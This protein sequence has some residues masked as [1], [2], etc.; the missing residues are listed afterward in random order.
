MAGSGRSAGAPSAPSAGGERYEL[1]VTFAQ[2][3]R[4]WVHGFMLPALGLAEDRV[5]T[6]ERFRP[7]APVVDE[8]ERAVTT[9]RYTVVVVSNA[10]LADAWSTFGE[11]LTSYA[12]VGGADRLIPAVLEPC[13]LPLRVEFRVR[14]D[15]T[16]ESRWE[17]QLARLRDLL[18]QS[19]PRLEELP[20]PYPGMQVFTQDQA[21]W[22]YGR[23]DESEQLLRRLRQ[24][25]L[26][27]VIGPSGAGKSSLV[28]AGVLP[29]LGAGGRDGG[30]WAIRSLRPGAHPTQ[31]LAAA[32]EVGGGEPAGGQRPGEVSQAVAGLLGR[33]GA[34]RLLLVVD[35]LEE[36]FAQAGRGEQTVFFDRLRALRDDERCV[37]LVTVRADFY[38]ELM[39]CPLWPL[40]PGERFEVV[41][42]AGEALGRAIQQPAADVG[43]HLQSALVQRL[44]DDAAGEPGVLP[45][46]QETLVLLWHQRQRRLLTEAAYDRLGGE[47][48]SALTAAIAEKADATVSALSP[49]QR[50]IA[51]RILLRLVQLGE[52]RQDTRR[53]EPIEAL[54]SS[55][56]SP[57]EFEAT[58]Q[59][60]TTNRL[61]TLSGQESDQ[62]RVD[63]AHEA[64][65]TG[66]PQ[67]HDWIRDNRDNLRMQRAIFEDAQH[68]DE[69]DRDPEALY[70]GARLEAAGTWADTHHDELNDL[71]RDFIQAS[72]EDAAARKR[73][74]R[75]TTLLLR[76]LTAFLLIAV[77]SVSFL[78]LQARR[79]SVRYERLASR[80]SARA[81]GVYDTPFEL[82]GLATFMADGST[83][84][85]AQPSDDPQLGSATVRLTDV[86]TGSSRA[87][88]IGAADDRATSIVFNPEG[89]LVAW[90]YARHP[91]GEVVVWDLNKGVHV[92]PPIRREDGYIF[93]LRFSRDS[94]FLTWFEIGPATG[95]IV[96]WSLEDGRRSNPEPEPGALDFLM[97]S[98]GVDWWDMRFRFVEQLSD[99]GRIAVF[100]VPNAEE[101]GEHF[102]FW[103]VAR[104][105]PIGEPVA[106]TDMSDVLD[107]EE[108]GWH[109]VQILLLSG[110]EVVLVSPF[111][112]Q[113]FLW[114]VEDRRRQEVVGSASLDAVGQLVSRDG[115]SLLLCIPDWGDDDEGYDYSAESWTLESWTLLDLSTAQA[116][117][118]Q[119]AFSSAPGSSEDASALVSSCPLSV[120]EDGSLV[121]IIS[122]FRPDYSEGEGIGSSDRTYAVSVHDARSGQQSG[123]S[124][125]MQV[126]LGQE[127]AEVL[128]STVGSTHAVVLRSPQ[129]PSAEEV[130]LWDVASGERIN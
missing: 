88:R 58:L 12:S 103:D 16:D 65:I 53:Q 63:L 89:N 34:G 99:D 72:R 78:A 29:G 50:E 14:L 38:A 79:T 54:H 124:L 18:E 42:L 108:C 49:R 62:P 74:Q 17:E 70:R 25:S 1:F 51:R 98:L 30:R 111:D 116:Q 83:V 19:D 3:D 129:E 101:C 11:Q 95:D 121:S 46:V 28:F 90:A 2:A 48:R 100:K 55:A 127:I 81:D 122:H 4:A 120:S 59:H 106:A 73:R 86:R 94:Q 15:L 43:V 68:W 33:E 114:H 31:A 76:G 84:A 109:S 119:P 87:M 32:L 66:W 96:H 22:F 105:L 10:Y 9:S 123:R 110:G 52:G 47:G 75:R 61:L 7:G 80:E 77:V 5:I 13:E 45:F 104:S 117:T 44:V 102:T 91:G 41:P 27:V 113:P 6:A 8:F 125:V 69:L 39:T 57:T 85:D 128:L 36:V 115:A 71:E 56:D 97:D 35:Q 40:G 24:Q 23:E 21:Q 64:L 67:L 26:V 93:N 126:P 20:C 112:E 60:L 107:D 130:V 92:A 37:L 82:A 118:S